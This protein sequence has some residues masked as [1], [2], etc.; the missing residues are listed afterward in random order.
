LESRR[1][2]RAVAFGEKDAPML[3]DA[4]AWL[5]EAQRL[6]GNLVVLARTVD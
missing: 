1:D 2:G 6:T 5:T 3:R 4:L